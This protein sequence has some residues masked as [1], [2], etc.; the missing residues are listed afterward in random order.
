MALYF[1]ENPLPDSLF[2]R[3]EFVAYTGVPTISGSRVYL[4]PMNFV[5]SDFTNV[6]PN[7]TNIDFKVNGDGTFFIKKKCEEIQTKIVERKAAAPKFG[8]SAMGRNIKVS[9]SSL[10]QKFAI[11]DM[12]G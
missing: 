12:Q 9:G 4:Y 7:F 3:K 10:G 1:G 11:L 5:A 8:L 2:Y 6:S